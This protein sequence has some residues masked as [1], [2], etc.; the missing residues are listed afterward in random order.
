M[1]RCFPGGRFPSIWELKQATGEDVAA[2][3][4]YLIEYEA[5]ELGFEELMM[6][7]KAHLGPTKSSVN[8][9]GK[10]GCLTQKG[11]V[12]GLR[13]RKWVASQVVRSVM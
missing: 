11:G 3:A 7:F 1:F 6:E 9:F 13:E 4:E 12:R 5:A 8:F 2:W 10:L